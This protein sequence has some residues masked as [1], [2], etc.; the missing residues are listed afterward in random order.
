MS[1]AWIP[2]NFEDVCKRNAGRQK[3]HMRMRKARAERISRVLDAMDAAHV[4]RDSAHGWVTVASQVMQ[5]S[6]ATASRDFALVRRINRQFLRM[7]G[8]SFDSKRDKVVWDWHWSHYGFIAPESRQAGYKK[9]VGRFPFDTRK[10]ETEE[11]YCG[12]NQLSWQN[13]DY[14][15]QL[16]TRDLMRALTWNYRRRSRL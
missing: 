1:T 16:S 15:A 6:K 11:S 2:K 8:R 13:T 5:I 10:Q 12:L 14:F 7:F 4:L 9:P 3:L